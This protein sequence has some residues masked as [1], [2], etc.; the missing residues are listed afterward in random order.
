MSDIFLIQ[1][2]TKRSVALD[3]I[4]SSM[5]WTLKNDKKKL[6]DKIGMKQRCVFKIDFENFN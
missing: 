4:Q 3:K 1:Y 2:L 5:A 6:S